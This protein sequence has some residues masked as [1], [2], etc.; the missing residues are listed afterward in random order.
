MQVQVAA[1]A[2]LALLLGQAEHWLAP[3]ALN[4]PDRHCEQLVPD[5]L[6]AP[7]EHCVQTS[8]LPEPEVE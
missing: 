7:A 4:D 6:Y 3:A 2:E 8:E 5:W 1:L